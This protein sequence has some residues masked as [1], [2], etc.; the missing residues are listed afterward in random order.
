V[1]V[2]EA[3]S[4]LSLFMLAVALV[5]VA[6]SVTAALV[7]VEVGAQISALRGVRPGLVDF[8]L[9]GREL[10]MRRL[11]GSTTRMPARRRCCGLGRRALFLTRAV[12]TRR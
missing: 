4:K 9:N 7:L 12:A 8:L 5:D 1:I 10:A 6:T 3:T 2:V 11:I